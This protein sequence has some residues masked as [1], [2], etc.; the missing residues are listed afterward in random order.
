MRPM[1][2]LF[3]HSTTLKLATTLAKPPLKLSLSYY[4]PTTFLL[5]TVESIHREWRKSVPPF[6]NTIHCE[7]YGARCATM[8]SEPSFPA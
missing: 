7:F 1:S 3:T 5:Y 8:Y 2:E 4:Q 6:L